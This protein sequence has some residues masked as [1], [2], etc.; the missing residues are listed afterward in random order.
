MMSKDGL[1]RDSRAERIWGGVFIYVK[2]F[3]SDK[4]SVIIS[5]IIL[6]ATI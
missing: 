4:G 6:V 5:V 2:A 3:F 1:F